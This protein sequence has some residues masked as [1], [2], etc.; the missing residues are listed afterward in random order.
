[1]AFFPAPDHVDDEVDEL[2]ELLIL[3]ALET[4]NYQLLNLV[5]SMVIPPPPPPQVAPAQPPPEA[6]PD[7]LLMDWGGPLPEDDDVVMTQ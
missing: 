6:E 2:I 4:D 5:L 1:M 3:Y 7:W